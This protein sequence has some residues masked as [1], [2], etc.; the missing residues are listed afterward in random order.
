MVL[1][2]L[3]DFRLVGGTALSLLLGHRI[4]EDIDLFTDKEYGSIPFNKIEREIKASFPVVINPDDAIPGM[5]ALGNNFGLHLF[6][7]ENNDSLIKVDILN[8]GDNFI[9]PIVRADNIRLAAIEEIAA[10]KLDVISRG[11]RKKDFWDLSEIFET[12]SL[13]SLLPVYERKYPYND[14]KAVVSGLVDFKIADNMPDPICF[15]G[16]HWEV[17]QQEMIAEVRK[18]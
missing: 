5:R 3:S 7:G 1:E 16:K 13:E 6:I 10:M 4:S 9:F 12:R 17:I 18:L 8:W 11:G 14:I 2:S 15:K